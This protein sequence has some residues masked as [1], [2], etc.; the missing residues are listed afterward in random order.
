[1][2]ELNSSDV[3]ALTGLFNARY[4]MNELRHIIHSSAN[5]SVAVIFAD[6]FRLKAPHDNYG[7][8]PVDNALCEVANALKS[9]T[10]SGEVACR[11][12]SDE[13]L[14]IVPSATLDEVR[15]RA[16]EL[17]QFCEKV[18]FICNGE[19][20]ENVVLSVG[21]ACENPFFTP[22]LPHSKLNGAEALMRE[23]EADLL[24]DR[25]RNVQRL[26]AK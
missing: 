21:V 7:H 18:R 16:E 12:G 5:S 23:T 15:Q 13:F 4:A 8:Q 6:I 22:Q 17:R 26:T 20:Q 19:A 24:R 3:D 2:S 9:M 11:Y 25:E 10:R 14:L 1:M